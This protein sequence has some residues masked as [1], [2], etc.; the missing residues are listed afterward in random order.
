[1]ILYL[2]QLQRESNSLYKYFK[3]IEGIHV[4]PPQS[5]SHLLLKINL[6]VNAA[7]DIAKVI[8][9]KN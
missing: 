2:N 6:P 4:L 3:S 1:M 9:F 5:G 7:V 8:S